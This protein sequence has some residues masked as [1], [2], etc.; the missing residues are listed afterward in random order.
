[1]AAPPAAAAAAAAVATRNS[2][3]LRLMEGLT[4]QCAEEIRQQGVELDQQHR[5]VARVVGVLR[6]AVTAV[7]QELGMDPAGGGVCC[8]QL[9]VTRVMGDL[10]T[11]EAQQQQQQQ[12]AQGDVGWVAAYRTAMRVAQLL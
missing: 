6:Q 3:A 1:M 8:R 9:M 2:L 4:L 5:L 11:H 12:Q 10:Q 7:Q